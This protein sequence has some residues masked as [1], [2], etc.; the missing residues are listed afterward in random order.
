[1]TDVLLWSGY[2][3]GD[4]WPCSTPE[5][6][7]ILGQATAAA[8]EAAAVAAKAAAEEEKQAALIKAAQE[9]ATSMPRPDTSKVRSSDLACLY[10]LRCEW[11]DPALFLC[12]L[13]WCV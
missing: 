3:F 10:Q 2:R 9:R 12:I 11:R 7:A 5:V 4:L 8:A 1:M 13:F 6:T